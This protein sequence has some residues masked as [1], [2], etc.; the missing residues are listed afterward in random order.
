MKKD[1]FVFV[2]CGER[3]AARLKVAL[4]YL[5]HFSRLEIIVVKS[6]TRGKFDCDQ[7]ITP[8]VPAG[9]DNHAASIFLKTSLHRILDFHGRRFCYLDNDVIAVSSGVDDIFRH[10]RPPVS[11]ASDHCTFRQFSR[12][13]V[14]CRCPGP[15]CGH[16]SEAIRRTFGVSVKS[17]TWQHW[18]GGV[19]VFDEAAA[20][21]MER[22][23]RNTLAIFDD[24]YWQTRDQG[25]LAATAWQLG[26]QDQP[27]LPREYN[28]IVDPLDGVPAAKRAVVTARE[29]AP[30]QSYSLDG[31][32]TKPRPVFLHF[33]NGG[34]G[35][36]GWK[37]WDEVERLLKT[38]AAGRAAASPPNGS[39]SPD[40]RIVHSLWIGP[41]LSRMEL[42]TLRSFL[43]H[44]HEFHLW[45][46]GKIET[47]LPQG[48]IT[49]DANRIIPQSRIIKKA[50]T[51]PETGVGKGSYSSPFSDLFRFKLLYEMGG[52]WVDMDVTCLRPFN[53][54]EPYVFRAHRVGVVGNVIKCPRHSRLMKSVYAT[55]AREASEHSA[56]LMPNRVL[57]QAVRRLKLTRYIRGDIWNQES[58]WDAVRPF[59]LEEAAIPAGWAA[60]HW[61]N[62]FW[63][64]L[65]ETGGVYR[66]QR[67]FA[68][69]PDK[70]NPHP[71]SVL[72]R[73]Y[74][75]H[76]IPPATGPN[77]VPPKPQLEIPLNKPAE[78][79]P[80]TPRFL[81]T[82]H[83]NVLLPSLTR[84]G[85]ER[86]VLDTIAG[87]QRRNSTGKLFLLHKVR[88]SY[89]TGNTG[90]VQVF[91]LAGLDP[92]AKLRTIAAEVLASPEPVLF[93]HMVGAGLLRQLWDLGVKTIPVIQ[94]ARPSW[95]D[96]PRA[97]AHPNV[98]LVAA[99][100]TA[101][102]QQLRE[103]RCPRPVTVM[104]HELQRWFTP[105]EQQ[106]NRR[107]IR[108]RHGVADDTLLIGMVG[109]FKSQKAY[110]RAVRVLAQIRQI[111]PAKLM[112]LGGWDHDWGHGRQ[113][114]TATCRL[115]L[116]LNVI[117]DLLTLGPVPDA[118]R[119]YAAFD[120]FLNTSAYEGL[121]VAL[122][123]AVQTGCPIVTADAG[124]NAEVLPERAVLVRD[125]S[126]VS[127]YVV[128]IAQALGA[129]SRVL[130]QKPHD[131]DLVPRLWCL[132]G[133][134]GRPDLF[135]PPPARAGTLF[136]T[137][138]L[139][140][141]GAQ[142]SLVNLLCHLPRPDRAWLCVS[143]TVYCQGYLDTLERSGVPVFSLH[144]ST[145]Y[146]DRAERIL[147]L[148]ERLGVRNV[149]FWNLD[150][151]LKLLLAKLLPAGSARLIEVSPGP[152]LFVEMERTR[153]FQRRISFSASDYWARLD[154]FVAKYRDGAPPGRRV[155]GRKVVVIPNGVP[156][157]PPP[158]GAAPPLPPGAD[159]NLLVGTAGR[160]MPGKRIELLID[161]MAELNTSLPGAA[162]VIVGGV[163]PRHAD[164]WPQLVARLQSKRLTS[165]HF[166]GPHADVTPFLRTFKVFVT[167]SESPGCPNA[168]LEAMACG[169]P[170]IANSAG[171]TA[172]QIRHGANGFLVTGGDPKELARH[173]HHLLTNQTVYRRFAAA[174]R[175]TAL[176]EFSMP[177]MVNRYRKLLEGAPAGPSAPRQPAKTRR[178]ISV[179]PARS[180]R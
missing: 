132:L 86:S 104:R 101:V 22:W 140:I 153:A 26:R 25:T 80:A 17:Q 151:R 106:E 138:N 76:Q 31:D 180:S 66:G 144:N 125:A 98:P 127:A 53:F 145:D 45:V 32:T 172:E 120:V 175:A 124:G 97:F 63:R 10:A 169:L 113:A 148:I 103:D 1:A 160:I 130:A 81:M 171:G 116:E 115:A 71:R 152:F 58:W 44:G 54:P 4:Q 68:A 39:L 111:R 64:M 142:R 155:D 147:C 70:E 129:R 37:N 9:L 89:A 24:P 27:A 117:T 141:G 164:Y 107:Q 96:P 163:D 162:L 12:Y 48:V 16:L 61:I 2:A 136:L 114:Y 72:A 41:A 78:R 33:V 92:A 88:P 170:V 83:L 93:T 134:Y 118:E 65:K 7:V 56:W 128:G 40:N 73:L 146:L 8:K 179:A 159:P 156:A 165:V 158:A 168:S 108:E 29:L 60:I 87:L 13:A 20:G 135:R 57:S 11:F 91:Q 67:L 105:E 178:R 143:E 174:A 34:V 47:P 3:H 154:H 122:L 112:I 90:G 59:A 126:D 77:G 157:P 177:L 43:R 46:Y 75:E 131:F 100:S 18:N 119:Y 15:E 38:P 69:A 173:V 99:V 161:L 110:T 133:R 167:I 139:N 176:R 42:L 6:R 137:D 95:Q 23:H 19:F 36:R 21:F 52:Y 49:E 150:A 28:F 79:Q 149:C 30:N 102:A 94:N 14:N 123:E 5:R 121:S 51:D 35:R 62:E 50:D 82:S 85:A 166:A 84:G 74:A 109:E 55:V